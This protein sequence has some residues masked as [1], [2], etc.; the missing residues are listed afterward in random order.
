MLITFP[1][2][3]DATSIVEVAPNDLQAVFGPGYSLRRIAAVTT[4]DKPTFGVLRNIPVVREGILSLPFER[5]IAKPSSI[6]E[7]KSAKQLTRLSFQ[8]SAPK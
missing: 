4:T 8:E 7:K 3:T 1:D 6:H 5:Y 2:S